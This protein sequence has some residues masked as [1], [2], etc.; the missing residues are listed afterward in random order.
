ME[1]LAVRPQP[2]AI[3]PPSRPPPRGGSAAATQ[4]AVAE[5]PPVVH[6][7]P[8]HAAGTHGA[9]QANGHATAGKTTHAAPG[10]PDHD[11]DADDLALIVKQRGFDDMVRVRAELEREA[12]ALRDMALAQAKRDDQAMQA[13]IKLI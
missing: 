7:S 9:H 5:H 10:K 11:A 4:P 1:A 12:N 8:A 6:G 13:W 3:R 2:A